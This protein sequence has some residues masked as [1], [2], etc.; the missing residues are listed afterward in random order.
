MLDPLF[1]EAFVHAPSGHTILGRK[2]HPLCAM[3]LLV[4]EALASPFLLDG[5]EAVLSDLLLAVWILSNDHPRDCTVGTLELNADGKAWVASLEGKID[6]ERDC[7]AVGTFF[8]DY[9]SLPEM[10]RTVADN[11]LTPAGAPWM[12]RHVLMVVR[13][14][15][16]PLY[17]AW[18]MGIGQLIWYCCAIEEMDNEDSRIV[19][20]SMRAQLAAAKDSFQV[21][22]PENGETEQQFADRIGLPLADVQIMLAQGKGKK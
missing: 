16:I 6:L 15:H 3:D 20:P 22:K 18:T 19:G 14:L 12:L 21:L 10:M 11:P 5:A 8:K 17:E 4:L 7:E 2:L 1:S 9:F 13:Q